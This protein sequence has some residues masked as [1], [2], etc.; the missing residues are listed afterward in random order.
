MGTVSQK[1]TYTAKAIDDIQKALEEKGFDMSGVELMRYGD[2]I[3]KITGQGGGGESS[4]PTAPSFIN[5]I[6]SASFI[7]YTTKKVNNVSTINVLYS[8]LPYT[9]KKVN[10]KYL[11]SKLPCITKKVNIKYLY[12]V[13][14]KYLSSK[15]LNVTRQV[16]NVSTINVL[17]NKLPCITKKVNGIN[18]SS[19]SGNLENTIKLER[20]LNRCFINYKGNN[21]T[22]NI[23]VLTRKPEQVN[24]NTILNAKVSFYN[25]K[26]IKQIEMEDTN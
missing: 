15:L 14:I 19:A 16:N 20:T 26:Q 4:E 12:K 13:N 17:Y 6:E 23:K 5:K 2:F 3:R 11:S 22:S 7:L 8:K 1:L 25:Q 18:G 21:T 10:I 9:T 24:N